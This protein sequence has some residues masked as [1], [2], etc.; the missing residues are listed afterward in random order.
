M[1]KERIN[2]ELQYVERKDLGK[3]GRDEGRVR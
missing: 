2:M 1:G 3:M